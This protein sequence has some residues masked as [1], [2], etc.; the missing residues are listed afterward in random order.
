[1]TSF[2][3]S[4]EFPSTNSKDTA[5]FSTST[6]HNAVTPSQNASSYQQQR[7]SQLQCTSEQSFSTING[8][9]DDINGTSDSNVDESDPFLPSW[10]S[11]SFVGLLNM[12]NTETVSSAQ[13][14]AN[15]NENGN[16]NAL[17]ANLASAIDS[18]PSW[19]TLDGVSDWES[20]QLRSLLN[21]SDQDMDLDLL[22][23][24]NHGYIDGEEA[25]MTSVL[26]PLEPQTNIAATASITGQSR[27]EF[28]N[29]QYQRQKPSPVPQ[30]QGQ[31]QNRQAM[32]N[33]NSS[34]TRRS[35]TPNPTSTSSP[36][37]SFRRSQTCMEP[38]MPPSLPAAAE[39]KRLDA[40]EAFVH[41]GFYSL[42][43]PSQQP[44]RLAQPQSVAAPIKTSMKRS[45]QEDDTSSSENMPNGISSATPLPLL[46]HHQNQGTIVQGLDLRR[47]SVDG[48]HVAAKAAATVV[49]NS[50][51]SSS[52]RS[53]SPA[54][55]AW[56]YST[57]P[58]TPNNLPTSIFNP[59]GHSQ[60]RASTCDYSQVPPG[61][62]FMATNLIGSSPLM[63]APRGNSSS[64]A[65]LSPFHPSA[66]SFVRSFSSPAG[67]KLSSATMAAFNT[68]PMTPKG[69]NI[70]N[71]SG[72]NSTSN[73]SNIHGSN[74]NSGTPR[75]RRS[76]KFRMDAIS[77]STS[78]VGISSPHG[79]LGGIVPFDSTS[80]LSHFDFVNTL[81]PPLQQQH[82]PH[83]STDFHHDL[84]QSEHSLLYQQQQQVQAALRRQQQQQHQQFAA[85]A[86]AAIGASGRGGG[87][88]SVADQNAHAFLMQHLVASDPRTATGANSAKQHYHRNRS[89]QQGQKEQQ[90]QST[91]SST[92]TYR[93]N[94]GEVPSSTLPPDHFIFQEALLNRNRQLAAAAAQQAKQIQ[95]QQQKLLQSD[96]GNGTITGHAWSNALSSM[97]PAVLN[98]D[99]SVT[100]SHVSVPATAIISRQR[101]EPANL[102]QQ[103]PQQQ[104][105]KA[106]QAHHALLSQRQ[107]KH[108]KRQ[109]S[110]QDCLLKKQQLQPQQQHQQQQHF[111]VFTQAFKSYASPNSTTSSSFSPTAS[112]CES[113]IPCGPIAI[114]HITAVPNTVTEEIVA[115]PEVATATA[116]ITTVATT[117]VN[118]DACIEPEKMTLRMPKFDVSSIVPKVTEVSLSDQTVVTDTELYKKASLTSEV[119]TPK[120]AHEVVK[121]ME[122]EDAREQQEVQEGNRIEKGMD[123]PTVNDLIENQ[124]KEL[125]DAPGDIDKQ[126]SNGQD[127][128]KT[129][130]PLSAAEAFAKSLITVTTTFDPAATQLM[131]QLQLQEYLH[132]SSSP[133]AAA[134][135]TPTMTNTT[136]TA[137]TLSS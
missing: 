127:P 21:L 137:Y 39:V 126:E 58:K 75:K 133:S 116:D 67:T 81:P 128:N 108:S 37:P 119:Q 104:H 64:P 74:S 35:S 12:L 91:T 14:M 115:T 11:E 28:T 33:G 100:K 16:S 50:T 131:D 101:P 83:S 53:T 85:A 7:D 34:A 65:S 24:V 1:M 66:S 54:P 60:T 62:P 31:H 45:F 3:S 48:Y 87:G 114:T 113:A 44:Q 30:Q 125:S 96:N 73:N 110:E 4:L 47:H 51:A 68:S 72:I 70:N 43:S 19:T 77:G 8:C 52:T 78:Q 5:S 22:Q 38:A 102:L 90:Q 120:P 117:I 2:I 106:H 69:S 112:L 94:P 134:T 61:Q 46:H 49:A 15:N 40:K 41:P 17:G 42:S 25:G 111:P 86:A 84:S 109:H 95:Q 105:H 6:V 98:K 132:G 123:K 88:H 56:A 97:T 122:E 79:S 129:E 26:M 80:I 92:T 23:K 103:Y 9:K 135:T 59:H 63:N 118:S 89:H 93:R 57:P 107:Q 71:N 130:E 32:V 20:E 82:T 18:T 124:S 27:Q 36:M 10:K 136:T 99:K 13:A 121:V 55:H 76:S 29:N